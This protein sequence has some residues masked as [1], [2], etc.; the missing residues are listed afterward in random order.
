MKPEGHLVV[1]GTPPTVV[2]LGH[3]RLSSFT[4]GSGRLLL[5]NTF[6]GDSIG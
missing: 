2:V 4:T 6:S 5:V 1:D 3:G